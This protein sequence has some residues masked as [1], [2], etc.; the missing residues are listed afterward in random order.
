M[1][2][3]ETWDDV[4]AIAE[5]VHCPDCDTPLYGYNVRGAAG[6]DALA[7]LWSMGGGIFDDEFNVILDER[8]RLRRPQAL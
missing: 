1:A 4:L 3:P 5:A 7:L 8:G 2:P 6:S